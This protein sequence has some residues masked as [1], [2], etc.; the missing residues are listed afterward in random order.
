M[1]GTVILDMEANTLADIAGIVFRFN[2][3]NKI[4]LRKRYL[5]LLRD[6][7]QIWF[8]M[9]SELKQIYQLLFPLKSSENHRRSRS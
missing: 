5:G 7:L 8:L 3:S 6:H 2:F 1:A 4:I 9:L